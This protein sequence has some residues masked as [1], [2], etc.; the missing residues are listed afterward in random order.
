VT[1]EA[2]KLPD[3][4]THVLNLEGGEVVSKGPQFGD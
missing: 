4:I 3:T 2:D 1:H